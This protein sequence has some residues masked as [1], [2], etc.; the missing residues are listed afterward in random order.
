MVIE[1]R[2]IISNPYLLLIACCA[3]LFCIPL[4]T[5][6]LH[7]N[8]NASQQSAGLF[9]FYLLT[10]T[11]SRPYGMITAALL[12]GALI[13]ALRIRKAEWFKYAVVLLLPIILGQLAVNVIKRTTPEP[14]PYI[15]W[16]SQTDNEI[17]R[18]FY[19]VDS[20]KRQAMLSKRLESISVIPQWEKQHWL[21][22]TDSAFPSGHTVFAA[23]WAMM[24]VSLLLAR[25]KR[26]LAT[27]IM[28]WA[29]G[30]MISRL[31]LGMHWP[32]DLFTSIMI[33]FYLSLPAV[34]FLH[35]AGKHRVGLEGA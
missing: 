32:G 11:V 7:W 4:S 13:Y 21:K 31:L 23:T 35:R 14:R 9:G 10:Q 12:V 34:Y 6:V 3:V 28:L 17:D 27:I 5:W 2:R 15:V 26:L 33:A 30:V 22:Q 18:H 25:G 20:A 29:M 16:L 19:Q 1:T 8:W 24:A